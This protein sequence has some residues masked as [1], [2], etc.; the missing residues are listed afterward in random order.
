[1]KQGFFE[2]LSLE[3]SNMDIPN[4]IIIALLFYVPFYFSKKAQDTVLRLV[5]VAFGIYMLFTMKDIRI[6]YDMK[7]LVGLGLLIPQLRFIIQFTRDTIHTIK[8]MSVNTYY[9]FLTLYYKILKFINWFKSSV[10]MIK[11]FFEGLGSNKEYQ[12]EEKETYQEFYEEETKQDYNYQEQTHSHTEDPKQSHGEF[13]Q[14]YSDS[15]YTVL[16]VSPSDDFQEIKKSY[17]ALIRKYHPDLNP[18]YTE[19]AQLI[20]SAY[21]KLEKIHK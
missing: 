16:G 21:E 19:I 9:F 20:N 13:D 14:F 4:F 3:I 8:M 18:E 5:Y 1:M 17:R 12:Q 7:M 11:S 6:L 2:Q 10:V 15:A